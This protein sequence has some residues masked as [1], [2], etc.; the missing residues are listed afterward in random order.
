MYFTEIKLN[1][2]TDGSYN[3]DLSINGSSLTTRAGQYQITARDLSLLSTAVL[4]T[5]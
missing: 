4:N 2:T 1:Q 3:V 5:V